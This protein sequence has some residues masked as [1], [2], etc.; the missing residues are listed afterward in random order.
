MRYFASSFLLTILE[1]KNRWFQLSLNI[2]KESTFLSYSII[3]ISQSDYVFKPNIDIWW[4][5]IVY[6]IICFW[7]PNSNIKKSVFSKTGFVFSVFS[8]FL[9]VFLP[10]FKTIGIF[11]YFWLP[12]S[13][14]SIWIIYGYF[15]LHTYNI[16]VI[17]IYIYLCVLQYFIAINIIFKIKLLLKKLPLLIQWY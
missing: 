7:L 3:S 5:F 1:K 2:L 10:I 15:R 16:I 13:I 12:Q 4:T 11:F 8:S 6:T 14:N 17:I 9:G